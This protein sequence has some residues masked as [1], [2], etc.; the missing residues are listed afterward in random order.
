MVTD[1]MYTPLLAHTDITPHDPDDDYSCKGA[2]K[3][4]AVVRGKKIVFERLLCALVLLACI[5]SILSSVATMS[6]AAFKFKGA[7]LAG[8][9]NLE[10]A[11]TYIGLDSV[12]RNPAAIP[13]PPLRNFPVVVGIVDQ[14][15]PTSSY[16]DTPS[17][18]SSFGTVYTADREIRMSPTETTVAQFWAGDY[19]MERC[20]LEFTLPSTAARETV[21]VQV[22]RV[23]APQRLSPERLA[24]DTRPEKNGLLIS[25]EMKPNVT[26]RSEEFHCHSGSFQAFELGCAGDGCLVDFRQDSK[27]E[28]ERLHA[29]Q[30]V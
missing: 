23:D 8:D 29:L 7:S 5:L 17:W 11:S 10:Y 1:A 2:A 22:W 19:G 3:D 6:L 18:E 28:A 24:W 4:C 27:I 20:S 16:P 21:F 30:W 14:L 25:Q 13:P 15:H 9:K 26:V 12:F